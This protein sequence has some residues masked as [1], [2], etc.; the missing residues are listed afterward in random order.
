MKDIHKG[1][2]ILFRLLYDTVLEST[3]ILN[4]KCIVFVVST[5]HVTLELS[6]N[7]SM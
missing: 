5:E 1:K 7:T 2:S 4:A 3:N 6:F